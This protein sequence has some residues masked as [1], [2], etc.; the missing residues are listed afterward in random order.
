MAGRPLKGSI[1]HRD[2]VWDASVPRRRGEGRRVQASFTTL[3]A[4][5][6]WRTAQVARLND[7]L[8]AEPPDPDTPGYKP[9]PNRAARRAE[10]K[11]APAA[12]SLHKPPAGA[13]GPD[14]LATAERM[15]REHYEIGR[16]GDPNTAEATRSIIRNHLAPLFPGQIP[17]DAEAAAARVLEWTLAQAGRKLADDDL[18][19]RHRLGLTP[20]LLPERPYARSTVDGWLTVLQRVLRFA[21]SRDPRITNFADG[22]L[23]QVPV[24]WVEYRPK[25]LT[26]AEAALLASDMHIINQLVL[27]ILRV[28]GPRISEPYGVLVGDILDEGE[29]MALLFQAQGGRKFAF[30]GDELGEVIETAHKKGGKNEAAYRLVGVPR[31]L[32]QLIRLVIAAFHTDPV[33]GAIDPTARLIPTIQSAAGGQAGFRNGL[34]QAA[35][36]VDLEIAEDEKLFP[37]GQRKAVCSDMARNRA[38]DEFLERRWVGHRAGK[39]VHAVVYVLDLFHYEDLLP[40]IRALE[41]QIDAEVSGSLIIPTTR[42][43]FYGRDAD[44]DRLARADAILTEAGWQLSDIGEDRISVEETAALLGMESLAAVRRLFPA[45]IPAVKDNMGR[46]QPRRDDV[47]A[48][49][50]RN[51][52]KVRLPVLADELGLTYHQARSLMLGHLDR[53]PRKDPYTREFLL[54]ADQAQSLRLE[55]RRIQ[56]LHRRAMPVS[57][58]CRELNLRHS[59]VNGLARQDI[60]TYDPETDQSGMRFITRASVEAEKARRGRTAELVV[61]AAALKRAAGLDD[62]ALQALERAGHLVRVRRR[63]GFTPRSVRRWMTGFR[64]SLLDTGLV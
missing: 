46:W 59:S 19:E 22:I 13:A 18:A 54:T 10:Q 47:L 50:D 29:R 55:R 40:A 41:D 28:L 9:S 49:R 35:L 16:H 32:A 62:A 43:P 57:E 61:T 42:R 53:P 44:L 52:K 8:E 63:D 31:Q 30:W 12:G 45:Q 7:G 21:A 25:M 4:A 33:T 2:G 14:F 1:E 27:W 17:L 38:I 37:H 5:E 26:F 23:A 3:A 56:A 11:T 58:A 34:Q 48:W 6:K 64:P 60:L 39:D 24:G 15:C 51:D 20:V 36:A